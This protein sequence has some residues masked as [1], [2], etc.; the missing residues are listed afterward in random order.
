[1]RKL[2][3]LLALALLPIGAARAQFCPGVTP[4][5]FDDVQDSDPFC[6]AITWMATSNVTLGCQAIDANHR[7]YCPDAFVTRKQMAAF[8]KRQAD[9]VMPLTCTAGQVMKWNGAVWACADDNIGGSGGGGT[10]TS[11]LAGTGL[12]GSPN[13][14]VGAGSINLAPGYQLP[15]GCT[16]GQVPKSNGAGGWTCGADN[17]GTG[18]VTSITAGTGLTGGTITAAGTIAIATGGVTAA[19]LAQNGCVNGQVLKW[20][21]SA[22]ACAADNAGPANA[23]VQNGNAFG[24]TA[25]LGTTDNQPLDIRVD[26]SRVM[27]YEAN[28]IS[29]NVIGGSPANNVTAGVRGATIAGG[30][31]PAGNTDPDLFN[32]A[33]NR[34]TDDYGTVGG[35]YGNRA[36]DDGGTTNDRYFAT[37]G[38]GQSNTA[39]GMRSTIGGGD[40]NTA[41]GF[42]STVGGG[43]SNTAS[44]VESTVGG[45]TNND[46]SGFGSTV[47]GGA[48]GTASGERSTVGG[49]AAN[50]A[51]GFA[52]TV[53]GGDG[54][55][56][57]GDYSVAMGRRAK[58]LGDG[59]FSF[60][61]SRPYDFSAT[62]V[63]AF[64]VRAT[65]G[66]RFVTDIDAT[67]ATTWSC[68][69]VAGASWAC[70]SD[71]NLKHSL[72]ALDGR[73]VL[74]KLAALPVYQ[75]QPKGQNAHV[76]HYGPM[77]QD[78]HAA[79]GLG[80]DDKM[81]GMQDAD[82]VALAA[83][84][85]LNAKLEARLAEKDAAIAARDAEIAQLKAGLV[86]L[87]RAVELLTA[88]VG[89]DE[90]VATR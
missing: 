70:S 75:W 32:E 57:A 40:T 63:N 41:S 4:W 67:G 56:A 49:G 65:G 15:Q 28:T 87:R 69:A 42:A 3:V 73:E 59:Q 64:R 88:R 14:I 12:Q 20:N 89:G 76:L 8:M 45:G 48:Y 71:R 52:S 68:L 26:N 50:T 19:M 33:P 55:A 72:V 29:P 36:G 61:D 66:V 16:N 74:E 90:R 84:Q 21:G 35:G 18:T 39:S 34:V 85:G 24:A 47:G 27:R 78:F 7:L 22:W 60:A 13:P 30:G 11:V 37:V 17:A 5:V 80:D 86:E 81:I 82:G 2:A 25:V 1:M 10:V 53:G 43:R 79:F 83:I 44:G 62:T 51:S 31:V 46:A 6:G 23:F 77:A 38:G 9:A 54:N 58:A